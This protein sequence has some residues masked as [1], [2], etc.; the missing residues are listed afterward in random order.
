M[1]MQIIVCNRAINYKAIYIIVFYRIA[2]FFSIRKHIWLL[3]IIGFP[4][5]LCYKLIVEWILGTEIPDS[6]K[7]GKGFKIHHSQCLVI[8]PRVV[9]GNNVTLKHNT[10]IGASTDINDKF[11]GAPVIGNNVIVH[12]HSIIIGDISIGNNV[13]IGAGS[14][15]LKNVEPNSIVVGN[16][17]RKIK[18]LEMTVNN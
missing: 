8:N 3:A 15:V 16:P 14:V 11:I 18:T 1:L 12:P 9:I 2:Y 17:A 10:T 4:I 7:I 6:V 5:R 13:I